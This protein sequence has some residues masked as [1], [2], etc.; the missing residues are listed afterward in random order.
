MGIYGV[1]RVPNGGVPGVPNG[2]VPGPKWVY[3]VPNGCSGGAI[4][5]PG[6]HLCPGVPFVVQGA[7]CGPGVPFVVPVWSWVPFGGPGC[8]LW[9][10]WSLGAICG[11]SGPWCHLC[12]F[13]SHLS[14][15]SHFWSHFEPF[16]VHF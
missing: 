11:I 10:F 14:H 15:L 9:Y 8:H 6:C 2:G 12:H 4:G 1:F 5:G 7:I 13:W 3:R 16:L